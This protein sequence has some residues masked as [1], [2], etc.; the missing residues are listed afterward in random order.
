MQETSRWAVSVKGVVL[1]DDSVVLLRNERG[2]WELPGGRLEDGE[3]PER[4]VVREIAEELGVS[5]R[6]EELLDA[7]VYEPIK[8]HN[9]LILTFGCSAARPGEIVHS[10]EHDAVGVFPVADLNRVRLPQGYR[11]SI[12]RW[13]SRCGRADRLS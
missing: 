1:W 3:T 11:D 6:A 12:T 9:V 7:W 4:C 10:N 2:E 5:A 8:G 13:R